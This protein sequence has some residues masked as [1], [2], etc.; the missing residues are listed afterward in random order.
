MVDGKIVYLWSNIDEE[1]ERGVLGYSRRFEEKVKKY[2]DS[3]PPY[4][5]NPV[6]NLRFEKLIDEVLELNGVSL[7]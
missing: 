7:N 5:G 3:Q 4:T 2:M 6:V 1:G